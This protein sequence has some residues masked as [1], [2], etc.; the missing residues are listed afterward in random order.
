MTDVVQ[1]RVNSDGSVTAVVGTTKKTFSDGDKN[2]N[3]M[4]AAEYVDSLV[5]GL[6]G[7]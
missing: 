3:L 6:E 5:Y 2:E 1:I 7:D 4:N